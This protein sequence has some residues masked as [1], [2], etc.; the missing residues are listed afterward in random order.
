M[1][2]HN[3]SLPLLPFSLSRVVYVSLIGKQTKQS[4]FIHHFHNQ[5][6]PTIKYKIAIFMLIPISYEWVILYASRSISAG[7]FCPHISH[8][9]V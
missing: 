2:A 4:I 6:Q 8:L 9:F 5:D 7:L 1:C 3:L